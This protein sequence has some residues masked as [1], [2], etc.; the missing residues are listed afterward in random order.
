MHFQTRRHWTRVVPEPLLW[1]V[2]AAV[3]LVGCDTGGS[4]GEDSDGDPPPFTSTSVTVE[5]DTLD[6]P[7]TLFVP[8]TS[9]SVPGIVIVH[10][11]G[12]VNRDGQVA[13]TSIPPIYERWAERMARRGLAVLRYDKRTT[14]PAVRQADPRAITFLDFV[15]DA[16]AAAEQLRGQSR[17]D[18]DRLVLVGHSQGGNV[19]PAAA[20]RLDGA[21]GVVSLAGPALAIDSL[22]VAQLAANGGGPN[23]TADGA[24]AQFDSLRAG[25]PVSDELIC[26]AG[27]TFW[28]QW[29]R[30][31]QKVDSVAAALAPPLL[32]QQGRADQNYPAETL[33]QNV[34]AWRRI[35]RA[36]DATVEVYDDVDHLFREAGTST[37]AD[38]PLDALIT[39]IQER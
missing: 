31:S 5:S 38:A 34:D 13:G 15:R 16:V 29:I 18:G 14:R 12:P 1:G 10:G 21:A 4:T 37:T 17:V 7:G 8:D 2:V 3:L 32:A 19:A 35:E 27:T 36:D 11:S 6:L 20:T 33:Q 23:C 28:R 30:H 24:R 25:Q 39:W 26:G 9:T 22:F